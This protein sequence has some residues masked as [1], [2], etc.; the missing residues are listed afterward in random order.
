MVRNENY[1][2]TGA[3]GNALPYLDSIEFRVIED[4]ETAGEPCAAATSTSS[5]RRPPP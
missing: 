2:R 1:W 5:P 4:S 3:D